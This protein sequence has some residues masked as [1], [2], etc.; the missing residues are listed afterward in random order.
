MIVSAFERIMPIVRSD[1]VAGRMR[2][3]RGCAT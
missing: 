1:A 2:F 3:G